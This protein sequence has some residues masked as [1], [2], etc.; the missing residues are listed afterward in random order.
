MSESQDI[1]EWARVNGV[2]IA[3][4]GKIPASVR[5]QYDNREQEPQLTGVSTPGES[6]GEGAGPQADASTTTPG[7]RKPAAGKKS[8]WSGESKPRE[9]R[10]SRMPKR[11]VP[12]DSVV[13]GAWAVGARLLSQVRNEAGLPV[14]LPVSRVLDIQAPV[15][16]VVVDDLARGT[17]LDKAL[18]P[19]ARAGESGEKAFALLGPPMI[20]AAISLKPELYPFLREP[21]KMSMM[22]WMEISQPAMKKAEARAR[23]FAEQFGEVDLDGMVDALFAPPPGAEW[24]EAESPQEEENIRKARDA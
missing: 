7:E 11:R 1:R 14:A 20:V 8:W 4:K 2:E 22:S 5:E 9:P 21:L 17:L 3:P 18:Q 13:S 10:S 16:G 19:L 12:I 24:G 23:K 15:A 6:T